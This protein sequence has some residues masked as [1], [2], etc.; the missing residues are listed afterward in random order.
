MKSQH[1]FLIARR[2]LIRVFLAAGCGVILALLAFS[3]V[4]PAAGLLPVASAHAVLVRSDPAANAILDAPP[5]HVVMWFSEDVNPLT[6]RAVVV[7][8]ANQEVDNKDAHVSD[9]DS[10]QMVVTLPLLK[11]GTYVVVW[12]T[13]SADDGHIASGSFIFRIKAPNG[14][15]PPIPSTLPTGNIPGGGG[16][17]DASSSG[18]DAPG[19]AQAAFTWLALL[20][21]VFWVGGVIWETWILPSGLTRDGALREAA[22]AAEQRFRRWAPIALALV[23]AAD[24][25]MILAQSAELAG[26]FSGAVSPPLLRAVLFGSR[27]GTFWWMRELVTLAA[28]VLTV[29]ATRRN[30]PFGRQQPVGRL[31]D[32]ADDA[33]AISGWGH[34]LLMTLR[35]VPQLPGRLVAGLRARTLLGGVMLVL[36]GALIVAFALSGHAA[37]VPSNELAYALTVDL[38]HLV[39]NAAWVGGLLYISV[40]FVPALAHLDLRNRARVLALGLPEFGAVAILSA[41][42]L[43]ATGTLNTT[44][45]LTSIDQFLTTAY[46]RTLFVKIELFLLMVGIS[47]WHAFH[48]RPQLAQALAKQDAMASVGSGSPVAIT[49]TANGATRYD[50][51]TATSGNGNGG[52]GGERVVRE[53]VVKLEDWL[54]REAML[55]AAVLLCAAL[56]GAFAA[57]LAAPAT[58]AGTTTTPSGPFLQ[59]QQAGGYAI[60][61]NIVPAKFGDNTFTVTLKDNTGQPV[62]D[63]IVTV[64][65]NDLDM[66]MGQESTQLKAVGADQPG[67]YSGPGVL[68]MGGHWELVVKAVPQG[69]SQ[70]LTA[71]FR[72]TVGYS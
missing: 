1:S 12:R 36:A 70:P 64:T 43:A 21:M 53:L 26:D 15:V 61:L 25:G 16:I 54:R 10:K 51:R 58:S 30:L 46:G 63:A 17:G 66:D 20:G 60:T 62:T 52:K 68:S 50:T 3:P 14:E 13:Q 35:R 57:T 28:L 23:L 6:S 2:L 48:V 19:I 11:A 45:H 67:V 44:I 31:D 71:S 27:F 65:T 59:T 34:E 9:D 32:A 29:L 55:G 22:L 72:L 42:L 5:S 33:D 8:T 37:A 7:N 4:G 69:A 56:L 39:C 38:F 41:F 18:L 49:I 47:A 24:I 40:V